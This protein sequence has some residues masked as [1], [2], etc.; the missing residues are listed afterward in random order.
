MMSCI[1]QAINIA[2]RPAIAEETML[3][4]SIALGRI[5]GWRNRWWISRV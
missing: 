3:S 4:R 2:S 1:F 5:S